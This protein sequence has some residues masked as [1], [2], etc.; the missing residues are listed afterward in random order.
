[1]K[2]CWKMTAPHLTMVAP[3]AGA[4]VEMEAEGLKVYLCVV[5]PLAGAWVEIKQ[6]IILQMDALRRSPRGSVG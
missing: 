3:L 6:N 2:S 4:W 5:A 1:M